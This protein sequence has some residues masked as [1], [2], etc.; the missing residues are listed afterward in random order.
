MIN[1]NDVTMPED[2]IVPESTLKAM[3]AVANFT[4]GIII[5][6]I[7]LYTLELSGLM[8]LAIETIL[9]V[10]FC[11]G[12]FGISVGGWNMT[13]IV[14]LRTMEGRREV[15]RQLK[16]R[17]QANEDSENSEPEKKSKNKKK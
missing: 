8:T 11:A 9:L 16:E 10:A 14:L 6:G 12:L 17:E 15:W 13:S 1:A 4:G 5:L 7:L 2:F 3:S